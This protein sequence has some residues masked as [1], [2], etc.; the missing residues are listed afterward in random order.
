M[1]VPMCQVYELFLLFFS[2]VSLSLWAIFIVL[3][4]L[5]PWELFSF[6]YRMNSFALYCLCVPLV[7]SYTKNICVE[8]WTWHHPR[9][10]G[11]GGKKCMGTIEIEIYKFLYRLNYRI[12]TS[13]FTII[14]E[15]LC[16]D[17]SFCWSSGETNRIA[18]SV[19]HTELHILYSVP[20]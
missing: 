6:V 19:Q 10:T 20:D 16:G 5:F 7:S 2:I 8:D 17:V 3:F 15:V 4:L 11:V 12:L 1:D 18:T 9:G 14:Y 13:L